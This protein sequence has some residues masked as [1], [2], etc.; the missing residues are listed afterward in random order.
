MKQNGGKDSL[1]EEDG[2]QGEAGL[3][4]EKLEVGREKIEVEG[5]RKL[6]K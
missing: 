6:E 3:E 5:H 2:G 4:R 1:T